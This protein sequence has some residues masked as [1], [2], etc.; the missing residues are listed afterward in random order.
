MKTIKKKH[1]S[2]TL[3]EVWELKEKASAATKDLS[4]EELQKHYKENAE[5]L[6]KFLNLK[7]VSDQKGHFK[8]ER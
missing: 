7:I 2:K 3:E 4:F 1:I 6:A 8:F 5:R